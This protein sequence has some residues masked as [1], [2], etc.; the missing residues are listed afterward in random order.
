MGTK[1]KRVDE[2]IA[3]SAP[4]AKP[5]LTHLRQLVHTACPD[6]QETIKWSFPHFDYKGMLCSMASFKQ[7]CAFGFWKSALMKDA[8]ELIGKNESAMGHLG[9]ITSLQDLPPDKKIIAWIREAVRLNDEEVKL[10]ARNKKA[11]KK[12]IPVP[13]AL[14]Q[15]L[16]KNKAASATFNNFSPSHQYE[17][18]EWITEAKTEDTKNKR[19][20]TTMEWLSEGKSRHWKYVKSK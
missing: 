18:L 20:A 9:K 5:V 3:K 10:P 16:N 4:F 15:A 2:Y 17:Y 1:D 6:V 19:I 11:T 13:D 8:G 14:R 12:D 7:H